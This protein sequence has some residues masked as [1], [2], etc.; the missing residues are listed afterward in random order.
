[1][2][3]TCQATF[4]FVEFGHQSCSTNH[5]CCALIKKVQKQFSAIIPQL[6]YPHFCPILYAGSQ[7]IIKFT[8]LIYFITRSTVANY[9]N[10]NY[11]AVSNE[12]IPYQGIY[13][14]SNLIFLFVF[15]D[16]LSA[17]SG[18][19]CYLVVS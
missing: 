19:Q 2:W 9:S 14:Y 5:N 8:I 1:M 4:Y 15:L 17:I 7:V 13:L 16:E 18:H 11:K 12:Q 6:H 10:K 3:S